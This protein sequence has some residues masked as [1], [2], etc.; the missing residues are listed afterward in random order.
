[1][2]LR[3][4]RANIARPRAQLSVT[5]VSRAVSSMSR[6]AQAMAASEATSN[7]STVPAEVASIHVPTNPP[8]TPI[9][10]EVPVQQSTAAPAR[11]LAE[12]V[13]P[14]N[15]NTTA[16]AGVADTLTTSAP[17]ADLPPVGQNDEFWRKVPVWKDVSASEFLSYRWGVSTHIPPSVHT[18]MPRGQPP[19]YSSIHDASCS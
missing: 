6:L 11:E 8:T 9:D 12:P 15:Y 16:A 14:T 10:K 19:L 1:M 3:L 18:H 5:R 7:A 13:P 2:F 4:S 17:A